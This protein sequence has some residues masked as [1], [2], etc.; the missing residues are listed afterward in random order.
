MNL[1]EF[2]LIRTLA[3]RLGQAAPGVVTGIGDDAAV[4]AGVDGDQW[5]VSTDTLVEGVHFLDATMRPEDVGWKALAVSISDIAAMGGRP[6]GAVLAV[7]VPKQGRWPVE[8]LTALYDGVAAVCQTF[9]CPLVGGDTVGTAGPLVLTS[10]VFGTVPAG[11]ARLRSLAQP[12][13]VVFVTGWVGVSAAGLEVLRRLAGLERAKAGGGMSPIGGTE[14]AEPAVGPVGLGG[15]APDEVEYL[16]RAHRRPVPQVLAGEVLRTCGSNALNDISDGLANE[17]NEIAEASQVRLRVRADKLP[18]H[19]AAVNA[20]RRF[21][22]PAPDWA[23]YGGEDFELVGTAPPLAFARA[24]AQLEAQG[25][26][27][28]QIGRVEAGD[29]VIVEHPDGRL[30][31]LEPRGYNHFRE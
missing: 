25:V 31:I 9:A 26:K 5:L 19:P 1:D 7:A 17:L 24:L 4:L 16:V 3:D 6:R 10:T 2:A 22:V 18:L 23:W 28:T 30:D 8:R 27:L 13:D 14:G 11:G 12:G 29:G 20:A 15:L 21:G